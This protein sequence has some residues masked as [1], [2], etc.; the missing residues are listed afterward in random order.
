MPTEHLWDVLPEEAIR[1][2]TA[3]SKHIVLQKLEAI[4]RFIGG[5]DVSFNRNATT[6][7]AGII[8][9]KFP[10]LVEVA[11]CAVISETTFPY[12]PGLLSFREVPALLKAWSGLKIKPEVMVLDGQGIAHPRRMG[13][14]SHFGLLTG[15]P[16]IGCAKSMLTG[17][18]EAPERN[19]GSHAWVMAGAEKIGIALR[20]KSGS[21]PIFI[22]PGYKITLEESVQLMKSCLT[23]YRIPAPTRLAHL[24]VN[25]ARVDHTSHETQYKLF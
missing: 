25:K 3:L 14:A 12:V 5:A 4:P 11:R 9:L 23:T 1:I 21:K 13:I 6:I 2:Q 20:S 8:V 18:Y 16:S 7:Y 15:V 22:S 17:K 19:A 24:M 10:E